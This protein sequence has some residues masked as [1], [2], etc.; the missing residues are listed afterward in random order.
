MKKILAF[1]TIV[2]LGGTWVGLSQ[3]TSHRTQV[4]LKQVLEREATDS[5]LT[6]GADKKI[7]YITK[8]DLLSGVSNTNTGSGSV[9]EADVL[10]ASDYSSIVT[11]GL[12]EVGTVSIDGASDL[13]TIETTGFNLSTMDLPFTIQANDSGN[14]GYLRVLS[15]DS[16]T[17]NTYR[18]TFDSYGVYFIEEEANSFISTP[19]DSP[20]FDS[21]FFYPLFIAVPGSPIATQQDF[22]AAIVN[23]SDGIVNSLDEV[24]THGNDINDNIIKINNSSTGATTQFTES[25]ISA[26]NAFSISSLNGLDL[27]SFGDVG[28]RSDGG[29][30]V[31]RGGQNGDIVIGKTQQKSARLDLSALSLNTE[32]TYTFPD[33]SGTIAFL[34]D[35]DS[36]SSSI[37]ASNGLSINED[38]GAVEIGGSGLDSFSS[39]RFNT[40]TSGIQFGGG[41]SGASSTVFHTGG[42]FFNVPSFNVINTGTTTL[43]SMDG[44]NILASSFL[45][46]QAND[47]VFISG[48]SNTG[49]VRLLG[50][51][52]KLV[53]TNPTSPVA[54]G[55]VW[56]CTNTDG[57][58]EWTT[59]TVGYTGSVTLPGSVVLNIVDGKIIS[60][61]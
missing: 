16:S 53:P 59:P 44:T 36:S 60:V 31:I 57:S 24:I 7:R 32:R 22:N 38:T 61:E 39:I 13:G 2:L 41:A 15:I 29:D 33:K 51:K 42:A 3:T 49:G 18:V 25:V 30:T 52:I 58:G 47:D 54:V 55:D 37:T 19:W 40:D 20:F 1:I 17:N 34:D 11:N 46:L 48:G 23:Y 56:T 21:D 9:M 4:K 8:S 28:L 27:N 14:I 5:I 10:L 12:S 26:T 6:W 43:T 50:D 45:A 35:I